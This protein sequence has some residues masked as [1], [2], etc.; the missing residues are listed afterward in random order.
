MCAA[1]IINEK[2][3]VSFAC[4]NFLRGRPYAPPRA[5][6]ADLVLSLFALTA[7]WTV[8]RSHAD[9]RASDSRAVAAS[10]IEFALR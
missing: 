8:A 9:S 5:R 4:G 3:T 1:V 2:P 7:I 10:P 6:V